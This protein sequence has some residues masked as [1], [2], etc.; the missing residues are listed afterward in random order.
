MADSTNDI[1]FDEARKPVPVLRRNLGAGMEGH[2]VARLQA[3]LRRAG[4]APG[5]IDG[6]FGDRTAT[7]IQEFAVRNALPAPGGVVDATLWAA[8]LRAAAIAEADTREAIAR[9][10]EQAAGAP[11]DAATALQKAATEKRGQAVPAGED[12]ER[13]AAAMLRAA[14]QWR[15]AADD[16]LAA[17]AVLAPHADPEGRG[18]R[19][20]ARHLRALDLARSLAIRVVNSLALAGR[21]FDAAGLTDHRERLAAATLAA[22]IFGVT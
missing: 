22:R 8:I 2:D 1:S 13:A 17:A 21:D 3:E 18:F 11:Q 5:S 14:Q 20:H 6:I 7:A 4:L 9:A 12:E 10:R 16:W 15:A 19:A